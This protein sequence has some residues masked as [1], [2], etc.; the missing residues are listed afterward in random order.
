M[1]RC[2]ENAENYCKYHPDCDF[3]GAFRKPTNA[4]R[5]RAMSDEELAELLWAILH[6]RDVIIIEKLSKQGIEASL[7][8][9]PDRDIAVHIEWL[10]QPAEE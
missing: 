5:I 3:C 7:I 8:E 10:K 1:E 4:D 9:V 2:T 6:E